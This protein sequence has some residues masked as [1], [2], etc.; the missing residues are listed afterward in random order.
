MASL[1]RSLG[2]LN[3]VENPIPD[4]T[5]PART[6][7]G[8]MGAVAGLAA[9]AVSLAFGQLIEGVSDT[10]PGLVLG[11]GELVIDYTPGWAAEESIENLGTA[12]K[13]NLLLGITV[14]SFLLA[15]VIGEVSL[16]R[17]DRFGVAGFA[18][19]G[20][21]GGWATARNPQSPFVSSWFWALVAAGLGIATLRFL[22]RQARARATSSSRRGAS[23]RRLQV[24]S[25]RPRP[26]EPSSASLP[27]PEPS[28]SPASE[29]AV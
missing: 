28:P 27:V 12:G 22:L 13:G 21:I 24:H 23:T 8:W 20:L 14:V 15:A 19:F 29:S 5:A 10:I 4:T 2:M 25:T 1:R 7:P 3:D 11:V 17:G 16:R 6:A 9:A 26:G 18:G